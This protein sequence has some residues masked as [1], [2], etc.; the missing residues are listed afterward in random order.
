MHS[1]PVPRNNASIGI[2]RALLIK[3]SLFI[4]IIFRYS[5]LIFHC[6]RVE[7]EFEFDGIDLISA[8]WMLELSEIERKENSAFEIEMLS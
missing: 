8:K 4:F 7:F 1:S 3:S 5:N 6:L 2:I